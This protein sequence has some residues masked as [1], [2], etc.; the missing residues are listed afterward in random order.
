MFFWDCIRRLNRQRNIKTKKI[1]TRLKLKYMKLFYRSRQK[2]LPIYTNVCIFMHGQAIGDG[3]ITSGLISELRKAGKKVFIVAS[4]R[5]SF[6]FLDIIGVDGFFPY[7][8]KNIR[9][10]VKELK[11]VNIDL[12]IDTFDFDHTIMYR[13][14]TLF[15]LKPRF[16]IGF[17][18]P[19][20]TIFDVNLHTKD[21]VHLSERMRKIIDFLEIKSDSYHYSL[22]FTNAAFNS[23]H[24]YANAIKEN[25]KLI[26]FNPFGSQKIRSLSMEQ[27]NCILAYLNTLRGFKTVVFNMG[28]NISCKDFDNITLNPFNDAGKS[29]ALASNADIIVTVDTAMVHLASALGITQY[30]IY[31]NRIHNLKQNNNILFGPN[32]VNARQL[33][34]SEHV[35]TEE[36]DNMHNFDVSVLIA[37]MNADLNPKCIR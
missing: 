24:Q 25:K 27:V 13:L 11:E 18:Q 10:L 28:E 14:K 36:G 1:K 7:K 2:K 9:Q 20:Q 37:A 12:V 22:S 4:E 23:A 5:V 34:T 26:I 17:D 16:A 3:I 19:E 31:N 35:N 32:N 21:D 29:F 30:C 15:M 6:L 33:T 8:K